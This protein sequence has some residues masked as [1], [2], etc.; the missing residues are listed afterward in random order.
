M[1]GLQGWRKELPMATL[2]N[3]A[4]LNAW[5]IG[6]DKDIGGFSEASLDISPEG[7]GRFHGNLSLD[8]PANREIEQS[9]YAAVRT[10]VTR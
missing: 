3:K 7:Y 6:S 9:G 4:D 8:L 10:K 1:E 5:A 2:N